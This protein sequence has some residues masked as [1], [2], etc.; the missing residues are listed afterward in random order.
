MVLALAFL[1]IAMMYAAVGQAGASGYLAAMGAAGLDPA[2]MKVT[3][4]ALNTLVAAISS[5]SFW[6]RG[7]LSWRA[8]YPFAILGFPFSMIGGAMDLPQR[9]YY[10]V[11]GI[12][13]I[14]SAMQMLRSLRRH[15]GVADAYAPFL[16]ALACGAGIGLVSGITGT[17]GGIFLAPLILVFGWASVRQTA[18]ISAVYN[19]LNSAAAL[20]GSG[21]RPQDFPDAMP[22]WLVAVAIGGI[23]GAAIGGRVLPDK[24]LRVIL[25]AIL[26]LSGTRMVVL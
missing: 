20:I 4:L 8:F 24:A 7:L 19:L 18:A 13:L 15:K 5:L 17:G 14:L 3:A 10:P 26:M 1:L 12:I 21:A 11:V 16:P 23:L 6:R 2:T 22:A 25:A 9:L